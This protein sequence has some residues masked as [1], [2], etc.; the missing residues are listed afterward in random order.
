MKILYC[1]WCVTSRSG[2]EVVTIETVLG[3]RKLGHDVAVLTHL[4]GPQACELSERGINVV[5]RVDEVPWIPDVIHSNHLPQCFHATKRFPNVPQIFVCHDST[6]EHS[7]PPMLA[8]IRRYFGV[9]R[10]CAARIVS[11]GATAE[12]LQNAVDL[13]KF[14]ERT[15]LPTRPLRAAVLSKRIEHVE[16]LSELCQ[17]NHIELDRFGPGL[18]DEVNNVHER[19]ASYDLVFGA[20]RIALEA[21]AVGCSVM[22]VDGRGLAGMVSSKNVQCWREHNFG[23]HLLS[24]PVTLSRLQSELELYDPHDARNVSGFVRCVAGLDNYL[25]SLQAIYEEVRI[26][27]EKAPWDLSTL[28]IQQKK[29]L[30]LCLPFLSQTQP[31]EEILELRGECVFTS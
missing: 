4:I 18:E 25:A 30:E 21:M 20:A 26:E 22:V 17:S 16:L 23:R 10:L 11:A 14:R 31:Y 28:L 15:E 27:A 9:D 5:Q 19:L 8:N 2:T 29:S 13:E 12:L 7:H 1:N 6:A 24:H 3:L